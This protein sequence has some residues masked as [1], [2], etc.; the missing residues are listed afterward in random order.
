[1]T[2]SVPQSNVSASQWYIAQ[3]LGT[4]LSNPFNTQF[5][6]NSRPN[7][8]QETVIMMLAGK[9]FEGKPIGA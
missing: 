9:H 6:N 7:L 1:M 3:I 5:L 2:C 8:E 4:T